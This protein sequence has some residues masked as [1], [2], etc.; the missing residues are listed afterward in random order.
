MQYGMLVQ[1]RVTD[2]RMV[3]RHRCANSTRL[4]TFGHSIV[5]SKHLNSGEDVKVLLDV[6]A[7]D[8]SDG[9]VAS[10]SHFR[11]AQ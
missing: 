2:T 10:H 4:A 9:T 6:C 3:L 8:L 11:W 1:H 7:Q 5:G